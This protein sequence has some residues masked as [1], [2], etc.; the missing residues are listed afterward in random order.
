VAVVNGDHDSDE[1]HTG[2]TRKLFQGTCTVILRSKPHVQGQVLLTAT[3]PGMKP[4]KMKMQT[5]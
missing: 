5:L 1:M 3:A 4:V 2:N